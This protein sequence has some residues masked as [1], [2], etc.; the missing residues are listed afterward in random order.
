M[1]YLHSYQSTG[2]QN[3]VGDPLSALPGAL[4]L[5]SGPFGK[6]L[7]EAHLQMAV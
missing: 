7:A 6:P 2:L 5:H 4:E 1:E 3:S